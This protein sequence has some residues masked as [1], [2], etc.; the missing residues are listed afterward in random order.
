MQQG[1][2]TA[3][4]TRRIDVVT[5]F[6]ARMIN[7]SDDAHLRRATSEDRVLYSFNIAD[8]CRLHRQW[9]SNGETHG[10]IILAP[11]QRYT[12]GEQLRRLL[13]LL[14]RNTPVEMRSRLEYLSVWGA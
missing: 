8:Y 1:L 10:G 3:L 2:V 6:E 4:R 12:V 7:R 13:L 14:A 5:A 11:Q 9:L